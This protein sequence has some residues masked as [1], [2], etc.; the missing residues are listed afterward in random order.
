MDATFPHLP[1]TDM[2]IVMKEESKDRPVA[3]IRRTPNGND[4]FVKHELVTLHRELVCSCDEVDGI[5]VCECFGDICS[6]EE[7]CSSW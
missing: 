2:N 5:V 4:R 7:T 6:E 1:R 3:I